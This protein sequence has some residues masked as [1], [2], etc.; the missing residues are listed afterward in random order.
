MNLIK[1]DHQLKKLNLSYLSK[2][3]SSSNCLEKIGCWKNHIQKIASKFKNATPFE[4]VVIDDFLKPSYAESIYNQF[5]TDFENWYKYENPI[6]VK[7][8][9]DKIDTLPKDIKDYFYLLSSGPVKELISNI[10]G[11]PNLEWDEY[12]HGA[13]LHAHTVNGRLN[14]HLDY[15]K[16]PYSG[17]H[18]RINII[19]FMTK[20]WKKEWNGANEL[21]NKDVSKCI[22]KT[23]VKFNRAILFKTND[24][25]W[26]GLP[27]KIKCPEN[28]WR[29]SLAYYYVSPVESER[30]E[31]EYRSK[32]QFIKRPTDKY[33]EGI[34][35]LYKIRPS[36]RIVI[37][38]L[39]EHTPWWTKES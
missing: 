17:M 35:E 39:K 29:K 38:D 2:I 19:L 5:P 36:R 15:E 8:A 18:R 11:I 23:N 20:N 37:S 4:C 16:H 27:D 26:H 12:L 9:F 33:D 31:E 3:E 22:K 32:A 14:I 1:E 25:S 28:V 30:G 10:S 34:N 24:I 21:W 7:H 13:G 6:E